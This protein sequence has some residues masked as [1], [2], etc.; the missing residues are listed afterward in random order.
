[1]K[2]FTAQYYLLLAFLTLLLLPNTTA[3]QSERIKDF[4]QNGWYMYFGDHSLTDK[5]G[6]HT[7]L[8]IRRYN[9]LKDPQQLLIRTGVNYNITD[10]AM[11]TLGYGFIET[12]PYGD[13]P[14][15]DDFVEHRIYEQLQLKGSISRVGLLHRYRLEQRWVQSPITS[16]YTYLN[17]ARYMLRATL[18][19]AGTTIEAREPYL[20]AYDEVFIGFGNNI[21]RNI[22]DQNR[23]Y[24]ALGYRFSDAAALEVGYLNHIVQKASGMVFEHNHTLQVGLTY[25]ID[26]RKQ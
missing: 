1:M 14:A 5:W 20:A 24:L 15:A 12:Y 10:N 3:A 23:A 19:L 13:F 9:L 8:Q 25:N 22:F 21:Q 16:D 2:K 17:R 7:E 4:N 11:F 6:V 18:P 26:F